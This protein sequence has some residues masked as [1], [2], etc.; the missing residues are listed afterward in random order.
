MVHDFEAGHGISY[1]SHYVTHSH[2]RIGVIP[3][4]YVFTLSEESGQ[5]V[6]VV[7]KKRVDVG[8]MGL[9]WISACSSWT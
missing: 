1:G 6:L 7:W 4:G 5:Q 9:V 2:E 3:I 8:K